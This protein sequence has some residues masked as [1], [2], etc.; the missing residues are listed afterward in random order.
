MEKEK[1]DIEIKQIRV[2]CHG[3]NHE[4]IWWLFSPYEIFEIKKNRTKTERELAIMMGAPEEAIPSALKVIDRKY[5]TKRN[6]ILS[7]R[8][9]KFTKT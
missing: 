1:K 4:R 7:W 2:K 5:L 9:Q 6:V 8:E 3:T